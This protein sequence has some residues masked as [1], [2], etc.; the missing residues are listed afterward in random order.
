MIYLLNKYYGMAN[1]KD[2]PLSKLVD[3]L[4]FAYEREL[5]ERWLTI[6]P[7][8]ES[9]LAEYMSFETYKNKIKENTKA[10]Q[11]NDLMTDEEI[12]D[13]GM[14]IMQMY[15]KNQQ[16]AGDKVGNI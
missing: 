13:D 11:H 15:E 14:K 2:Y 10:K 5:Y 6:Y 1:I 3:F 4:Q 16:R 7:L 9:G 8:M 12:I